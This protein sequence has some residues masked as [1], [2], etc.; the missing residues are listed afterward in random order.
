MSGSQG[1]GQKDTKSKSQKH[2]LKRTRNSLR[3]SSATIHE[4]QK[5][6]NIEC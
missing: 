3:K 4:L 1:E 2:C 6:M 5:I